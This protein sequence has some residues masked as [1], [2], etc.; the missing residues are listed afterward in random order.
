MTDVGY[1]IA[2]YKSCSD[3]KSTWHAIDLKEYGIAVE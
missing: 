1:I 3:L 2:E